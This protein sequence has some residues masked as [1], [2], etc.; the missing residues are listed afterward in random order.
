[1][2][3]IPKCLYRAYA[4]SRIFETVQKCTVLC[5]FEVLMKKCLKILFLAELGYMMPKD[6]YVSLSALNNNIFVWR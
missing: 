4:T 1:M 3:L 5:F 6:T 2:S